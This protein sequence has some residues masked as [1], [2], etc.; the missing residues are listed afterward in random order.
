MVDSK[1]LKPQI[2]LVGAIFLG[3]GSILGTG[4]FVSLAIAVSVAG[5]DVFLAIGLAAAT[6]LCNGLSAAQL[7]AAHPVSGGT[8]AYG[9]RYLNPAAGFVA[10]W[11]FLGAKSASAA[12]AALGLAQYL[13]AGLGLTGNPVGLALVAVLA[14]T[15]IVASGV[16]RSNRVNILM[17]TLTIGALLSFIVVGFIVV[18][19][20]NARSQPVL[21]PE[22][23]GWRAVL[24]ASAL[25]FVAYTGYGRIT[26]MTEEVR[27]PQ[28]TI[29]IAVVSTLLLTM[30][31]YLG[32]AAVLVP[33][34]GVGSLGRSALP[35][36]QVVA[37]G[38]SIGLGKIVSLGAITAMLGV[39]LNL[40]LGLSR[41]LMAMGRQGDMPK[42]VARLNPATTTPPIAVAVMGGMVALLV[43][44][45]NVKTTWSLSAFTVL[46]YYTLTNLAALRLAPSERLYPRW[47]AAIGL[48]SCLTLAFWVE[49]AIWQWGLGLIAI[50]LLGKRLINKS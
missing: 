5:S 40:I 21:G 4:V 3:L 34:L 26:T 48:I 6:A 17:V 9:Y 11:L 13:A 39:L 16:Q 37:A 42:V 22:G 50:G 36:L 49:P 44:I 27:Q 32:V 2:G 25:M 33:T 10:G 12:T 43:T 47:I 18:G 45:G 28:R 38:W 23:Q 31:L 8:Y 29:P 15:T 20:M 1:A 24:E 46:I 30:M 35:P 19:G 7:A 14:V 41:V